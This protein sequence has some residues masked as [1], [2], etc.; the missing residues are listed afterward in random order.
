MLNNIKYLNT[1]DIQGIK[2]HSL[3]ILKGTDLETLYYEKG[4]K[5]LTLE[6]YVDIIVSQIALLRSDGYKCVHL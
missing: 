5:V 3:F 4:F 1:L 6:E 2:I